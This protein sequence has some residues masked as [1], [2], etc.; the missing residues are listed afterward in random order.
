MIRV[1]VSRVEPP[2][3]R[4]RIMRR[5]C[6]A[7]ACMLSGLTVS[8]QVHKTPQIV[9]GWA[10]FMQAV[11]ALGDSV[12]T[13]E[14]SAIHNED[15]MLRSAIS[16]LQDD[17][18]RVASAK[19]EELASGLTTFGQQLGDLHGA[20]DAF[21]APQTKIRLQKLLATY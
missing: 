9:K 19:Q 1:S 15:S 8:A 4:S 14:L 7:I 12:A 21:N 5:T 20:A 11:K 13:G 3:P 18:K 10:V 17:S 6:V 2:R 16:I